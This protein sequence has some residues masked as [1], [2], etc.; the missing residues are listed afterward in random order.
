MEATGEDDTNEITTDTDH[1]LAND[2][3]FHEILANENPSNETTTNQIQARIRERQKT[4]KRLKDTAWTVVFIVVL[5]FLVDTLYINDNGSIW[6][7]IRKLLVV[8]ILVVLVVCFVFIIIS[9]Y[10][11]AL[12]IRGLFQRLNRNPLSN[13]QNTFLY[14]MRGIGS[15]FNSISRLQRT[16]SNTAPQMGNHASA[17]RSNSWYDILFGNLFDLKKTK[18]T[19]DTTLTVGSEASI[20]LKFRKKNL[21]SHT[22]LPTQTITAFIKVNDIQ[23]ASTITHVEAHRN[24]ASVFFTP[25]VAGQYEITISVDN[26]PIT[27][28]PII[29]YF[30]PGKVDPSKSSLAIPSSL[31]VLQ[32]RQPETFSLDEQDK[33]GNTCVSSFEEL[34]KYEFIIH[35]IEGQ[36]VTPKLSFINNPITN[37][38]TNQG[39][40]Q[41]DYSGVYTM[42]VYYEGE[43]LRSDVTMIVLTEKEM[44]EV[45]KNIT[46]ISW[47]LYYECYM[48]V[49][50]CEKNKGE[51]IARRRGSI[52][53]NSQNKRKK[54]YCYISTRHL[55][56]KEFYLKIIPRT[57]YSYRINPSLKMKLLTDSYYGGDGVSFESPE[58]QLLLYCKQRNVMVATIVKLLLKNIGGSESFEDKRSYFQKELQNIGASKTSSRYYFK[59]KR[60]N[61]LKDSLQIYKSM[62]YNDW[63]K[64]FDVHFTGEEGID[65][66]GLTREWMHLLIEKLFHQKKS[67]FRRFNQDDTQGL[68]HPNHYRCDEF[69]KLRLYELAGTLMAKCLI[70]C[71]CDAKRQQYIKAKFTRSF[72]SQI[73]G[74]G[75]N[76]KQFSSDDKQFYSGKIKYIVDNDPQYL[77]I[78]FTEDVYDG[79]DKFVKTVDLK[80]YGS[81]IQVTNDNK[82]EYIQR[83]AEY[84]L[85]ESVKDEINAFLKGLYS[86]IPEGLLSIFNV[87]E[88]ELLI[89]GLG[90]I[91]VTDMKN[92]CEE[93]GFSLSFMKVRSWFWTV[94]SSF[95][96]EELSRLIQFST[97]CSQLPPEGFAG[98]SPK[99]Q[100]SAALSG[101]D[102]LPSAHTCFNNL[103]LP[104][105]T[106]IEILRSKLL[107]A[108]TEGNEGFGLS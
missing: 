64:K 97:G 14:A 78:Y 55:T 35:T 57:L 92:N 91:S 54:V 104:D 69:Q 98:L 7:Q 95:N 47:N 63:W 26:K 31:F 15:F 108:I 13:Q 61:L 11:L 3:P 8:A 73:L 48:C 22:L 70:E 90:N 17:S 43:E 40:I 34:Y 99:F 28:E 94:I 33:Y 12:A 74:L 29:K 84:R 16:F 106:S 85:C 41:L 46:S 103:C 27:D 75:V 96:Q 107:I 52:P 18:V 60:N 19:W 71:S 67:L 42:V 44:L 30:K 87:N 51:D 23:V 9:T 82:I 25:I 21:T 88:L 50:S 1:N 80:A 59:I 66:G 49:D 38:Q 37:I 77:D 39:M 100:I 101:V 102:S 89:C 24:Q 20:L 83:L 56:I 10:L 2:I 81:K 45:I 68:I 32:E 79:D 86:L 76:W 93:P 36:Q 4:T 105:Y 53:S 62:S 5:A 6:I 65:Y 58:L 72:L